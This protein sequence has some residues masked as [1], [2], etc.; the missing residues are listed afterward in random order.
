MAPLAQAQSAKRGCCVRCADLVH[1]GAWLQSQSQNRDAQRH[2][3]LQR[4]SVLAQGIIDRGQSLKVLNAIDLDVQP[5]VFPEG[6][7]ID[8]AFGATAYCLPGRLGESSGSAQRGKVELT[9]R[10]SSVA[11]IP[12]DGTQQHTATGPTNLGPGGQYSIR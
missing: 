1:E 2:R 3:T 6:V 9:Q 7:E 4:H 5:D 12:D 10:L 8:A 11:Y